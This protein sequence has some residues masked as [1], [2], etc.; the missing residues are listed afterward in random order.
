MLTSQPQT[1]SSIFAV[2][3]TRG[4]IRVNA[5]SRHWHEGK[6]PMRDA[7]SG[8]LKKWC[9]VGLR[10]KNMWGIPNILKG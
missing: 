1:K 4:T 7:V 9:V 6:N 2:L 8:I 3:G 10:N 5:S